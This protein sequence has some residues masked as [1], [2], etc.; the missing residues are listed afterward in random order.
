MRTIG[1]ASLALWLFCAANAIAAVDIP[2]LGRPTPFY[3]GAGSDVKLI[4]SAA[5]TD[6]TIDDSILLTIRVENLV[7]AKDVERINLEEIEA[8]HRDFQIADELTPESE[9]NGTRIFRYRLRPRQLSIAEIPRLV[10]PYYDPKLPQP[11]D[12][13]DFPF[14]R[15]RSES[16]PIRVRKEAPP[17]IPV[18]PLDV[19]A[20][21]MSLA[22][23]KASVP[24][25][26]WW[27]GAFAPPVVAIGW[28]AI[29]R[30]INPVGD[31][32]VRRRRSRA[33]RLAIKSLRHADDATAIV[34]SVVIYLAEHFELPGIIRVPRDLARLLGDARVD[35]PTID[36]CVA[37]INASDSVR[38]AP[39]PVIEAEQLRVQGENL[40]RRLEGER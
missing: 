5:P 3:G 36:E 17:P 7:N 22:E 11:A 21:A 19:P 27:I 2:V 10:F 30:A 40:I 9:P 29:W 13:P 31:R 1:S 4:V 20:F 15:A 32:L 25:W 6:V 14:R 28:C 34:Q 26:I 24:G 33:A 35:G 38:F 23:P 37:F 18:E 12:K 39:F 8:F 16:I